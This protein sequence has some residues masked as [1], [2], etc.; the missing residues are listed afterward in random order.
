[1]TDFLSR[2]TFKFAKTMPDTPHFYV[3]RSPENEADYV[4]LWNAWRKDGVDEKWNGRKYRYWYA[5]DGWK[6][7]AMTYDQSKSV[8]INRAKVPEDDV[9]LLDEISF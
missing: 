6:Y 4:A 5:G 1:M 9:Q 7:W 2:L 3:V 8:I